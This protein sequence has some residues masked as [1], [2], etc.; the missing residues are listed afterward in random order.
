MVLPEHF[1]PFL[2]GFGIL[3]HKVGVVED[4][5]VGDILEPLAAIH[6]SSADQADDE[7]YATRGH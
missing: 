3:L 5:L 7:V 2:G 6:D 4:K 1:F